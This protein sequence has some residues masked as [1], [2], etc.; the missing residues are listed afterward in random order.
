MTDKIA[1]LPL[2]WIRAEMYCHLT[3]ETMESIYTHIREFEW[4]AGKHYK[5][6]GKRTLWINYPE[7]QEWVSKQ[8]HVESEVKICRK[9]LKSVPANED[10]ASA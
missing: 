5:R 1:Y 2:G 6:T 7:A 3:G 8:P 4:A 9:A 10:R